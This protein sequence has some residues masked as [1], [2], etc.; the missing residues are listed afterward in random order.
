VLASFLID[1]DFGPGKLQP[2]IR[3]EEQYNKEA[4]DLSRLETG[5]NYIIRG[6][7]AKVSL[8]YANVDQHTPGLDNVNQ[9]IAGLQLQY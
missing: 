5:V 1:H 8:L 2:V 9:F 6:S 7:D 4:S 3:Y